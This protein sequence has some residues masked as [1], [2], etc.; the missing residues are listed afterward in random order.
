[1]RLIMNDGQLQTVEQVRQVLEGSEAVEFRGL[2]AK[3]KYYWIDAMFYQH[4]HA[5]PCIFVY[6]SQ[7]SKGPAFRCPGHHEVIAPP[8]MV[9]MLRP[10]PNT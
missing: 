7:Y 5:F 1:M 10:E 4:G 6:H 2:T 9:F 8:Y 3:E